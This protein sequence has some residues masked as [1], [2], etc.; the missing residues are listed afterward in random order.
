MTKPWK[1][2]YKFSV[3]DSMLNLNYVG[4]VVIVE[5]FHNGHRRW[6]RYGEMRSRYGEMRDGLGW[7]TAKDKQ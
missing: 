1:S 4:V 5:T 7:L 2:H 3:K 6:S